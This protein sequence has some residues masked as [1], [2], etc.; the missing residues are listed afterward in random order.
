MSAVVVDASVWISSLLIRDVNHAVSRS[1]R[2][3]WIAGGG[4]FTLPSVI[5][6]E[7]AGAIARRTGRPLLGERAV[8][9]ILANPANSLVSVD[10]SLARLASQ[11]AATLSL[12]G[13]DAVYTAL[14]EQ[15]GLL[16]FT[17]DGEQLNRAAG[18][19]QV[20]RPAI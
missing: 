15:M 18:R 6:P 11:H 1:W 5:L 12:K 10:Q 20:Q 9:T 19:I 2:R 3:T 14:A 17:W 4:T 8:A 7:I 13:S 16:L